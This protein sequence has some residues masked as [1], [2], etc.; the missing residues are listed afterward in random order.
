M[1]GQK[2]CTG[3]AMLSKLQPLHA[4]SLK[5]RQQALERDIALQNYLVNVHASQ[6]EAKKQPAIV[7]SKNL[8]ICLKLSL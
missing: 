7:S 8:V 4:N 6:S 3:E 2:I 5:L 1:D